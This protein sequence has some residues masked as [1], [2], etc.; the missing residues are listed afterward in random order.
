MSTIFAELQTSSSMKTYKEHWIL[1]TRASGLLS[2]VAKGPHCVQDLVREHL[3]TVPPIPAFTWS[4]SC[5][6]PLIF[7]KLVEKVILRPLPLWTAL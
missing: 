1:H 5:T 7:I 2:G 4:P 3:E 6:S